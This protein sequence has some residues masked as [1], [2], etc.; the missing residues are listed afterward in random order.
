MY[1]NPGTGGGH[2]SPGADPARLRLGGHRKGP[3][4]YRPEGLRTSPAERYQ[5]VDALRD[6]VLNYLRGAPVRASGDSFRYRARKLVVRHRL[7][8]LLTTLA[9]A[10]VVSSIFAV[11][12]E[13]RR[14]SRRA[15]EVRA[16][17]VSVLDDIVNN[18]W[19]L[20]GAE[21]A[22]Y[23]IRQKAVE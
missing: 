19:S 16:L 6:D 20:P 15:D 7:A 14:A 13:A 5:S 1:G 22:N 23:I 2:P 9:A 8:V 3:R 17:S 10:V 12:F 11:L 21:Q 18:T 4:E